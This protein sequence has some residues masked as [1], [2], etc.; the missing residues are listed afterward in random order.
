[1]T[2]KGPALTNTAHTIC[3]ERIVKWDSGDDIKDY[4]IHCDTYV[5]EHEIVSIESNPFVKVEEYSDVD[6]QMFLVYNTNNQDDPPVTVKA[7]LLTDESG[8]ASFDVFVDMNNNGDFISRCI[9]L[10]DEWNKDMFMSATID[11]E[12]LNLW[13]M[14]ASSR[15]CL[16]IKI[17]EEGMVFDI[18][19][20]KNGDEEVIESLGWR[21]NEDFGWE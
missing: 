1:M 17:E 4:C 5:K 19:L 13:L 20:E 8:D 18:L 12:Y 21:S 6:S 11:S 14:G 3:G 2:Y 9:D 15:Y 10:G 7:S 16:Q